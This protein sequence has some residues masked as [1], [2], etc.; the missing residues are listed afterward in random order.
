MALGEPKVRF[1]RVCTYIR[2]MTPWGATWLFLSLCTGQRADLQTLN[3]FLDCE[4]IVV[5]VLVALGGPVCC[6]L[7]RNDLAD[8]LDD[9]LA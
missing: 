3:E 6:F 2:Y 4:Y 5:V 9:K 1:R 8:V 7:S